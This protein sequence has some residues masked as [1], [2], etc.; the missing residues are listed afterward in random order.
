MQIIAKKKLFGVIV[1]ESKHDTEAVLK[2]FY[3]KYN[4]FSSIQQGHHHKEN[5]KKGLSSWKFYLIN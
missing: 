1:F 2:V 5:D 3:Q 4:L